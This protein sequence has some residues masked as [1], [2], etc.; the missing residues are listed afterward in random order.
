MC[1]AVWKSR[2]EF[3]GDHSLVINGYQANFDYL[4][5]GLFYF[6]HEVDGCFSTMAL[7]AKEFYDLNPQKK[8]TERK[9][10]TDECPRHCLDKNNLKKCFTECECAYVRELLCRIKRLKA[11]SPARLKN[12]SKNDV[13]KADFAAN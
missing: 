6:T 13:A 4:E 9:T 1:S 12:I 2:N 10:F 5:Y 11:E 3:I 8:F 7:R